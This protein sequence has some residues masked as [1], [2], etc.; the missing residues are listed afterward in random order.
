MPQLPQRPA[1]HLALGAVL[2]VTSDTDT[3][4]C[5]PRVTMPHF[6]AGEGQDTKEKSVCLGREAG[7]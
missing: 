5:V 4:C 7:I 3:E 2:S 1:S 6:S